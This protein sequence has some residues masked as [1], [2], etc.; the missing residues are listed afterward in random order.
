MNR[1]ID[2]RV[3]NSGSLMYGCTVSSPGEIRTPVEGVL[4]L[5]LDVLILFV[6]KH[7]LP[8]GGFTRLEPHPALV[9]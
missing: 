8:E 5:S 1:A 6:E 3:E 2:I 4:S 9:S 7:H